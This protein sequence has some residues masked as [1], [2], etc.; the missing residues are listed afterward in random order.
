M[1]KDLED[2]EAAKV[3]AMARKIHLRK[4]LAI[5][6]G[7][8]AKAAEQELA[9]IT[10]NEDKAHVSVE[11]HISLPPSLSTSVDGLQMSPQHWAVTE[12]LPGHFWGSP[13]PQALGDDGTVFGGFDGA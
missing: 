3:A 11:A 10:E 12:R 6:T 13:G 7:K 9:C 2:K 1:K 4:R 5:S 8:E